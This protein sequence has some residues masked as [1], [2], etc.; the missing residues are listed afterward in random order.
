M[1]TGMP[2]PRREAANCR[3]PRACWQPGRAASARAIV[4][5][6]ALCELR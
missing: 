6:E 5:H 2:A 4:G 1:C 3:R